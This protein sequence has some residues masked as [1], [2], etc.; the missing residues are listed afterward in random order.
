MK[1]KYLLL[2]CLLLL[3]V[4]PACSPEKEK[5]KG[6]AAD[7]KQNPVQTGTII[8]F[9]DNEGSTGQQDQAS[10]RQIEMT[11]KISCQGMVQAHPHDRAVVTPPMKG[12]VRRL[13]H[14]TGDRVKKGEILVKLS[15]PDYLKL[16][17]EY[18][19]AQSHLEYYRQEY[20]RQAEL[21]VDEAAPLNKVQQ[22]KARFED[23]QARVT[24]MDKQ[25]R[26]L[27]INPGQLK[28]GE[29]V[30]IIS[31]HTPIS[32]TITKMGVKQGALANEERIICQIINQQR[33]R[34]KL[35]VHERHSHEIR[36]DQK[37]TF[38]PLYDTTRS[39]V[40]HVEKISNHV[41]PTSHTFF[42]YAPLSHLEHTFK[43]GSHV[44]AFLLAG[45]QRVQ[46]VPEEALVTIENQPHVLVIRENGYMPVQVKTGASQ[47]GYVHIKNPASLAGKKFVRQPPRIPH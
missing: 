2:F 4:T 10:L 31:L 40:S 14:Q 39:Y 26:M 42:V 28:E 7:H 20:K 15:H 16:Q 22:A 1:K 34:L 5:S 19:S 27:H 30:S 6:E 46:T 43:H 29:P 12:F 9:P 24:S 23:Y 47:K 25:L 41:D 32:G 38:H 37:I 44:E 17:Q 18:L 35:E 11:K 36:V 8:P 3:M 13:N 21:A 45:T 33:N